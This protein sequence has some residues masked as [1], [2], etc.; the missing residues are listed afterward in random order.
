[1]VFKI[2]GTWNIYFHLCTFACLGWNYLRFVL[3]FYGDS[4]A[5]GMIWIGI[6]IIAI[7]I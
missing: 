5:D 7:Y 1:M 4:I 2:V 6:G 3:S